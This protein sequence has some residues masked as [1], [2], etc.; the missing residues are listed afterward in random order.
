MIKPLALNQ[1]STQIPY[2]DLKRQFRSLEKEIRQEINGVLESGQFVLGSKVQT[3]EKS[4]AKYLGVKH[5]IGVASG[6]DALILAF[7]ALGIGK[8]DQVIVP[9]YTYTAS[10]F[11]FMH[12]GAEPVFV[13]I[14]PK[15]FCINPDLIEKAITP[16]TK[17]I[18]PVHL[19]GQAANMTAIMKIARK[20]KLKV[21]ED[22]AQ[23][24]GA[25]W[26]GKKAGTFGDFGCFSFYPTKNLGAYGDGGM[27]VTNSATLAKK[28]L[29]LRNLGHIS[30][31]AD[32]SELG[33]TSRL[34]ELQACVLEIKLKH[35]DDF[36]RK[37]Y[38]L[39]QHYRKNLKNTPVIFP[40]EVS[41][42]GS[43]Y[44]L[45]VARIPQGKRETLRDYLSRQGVTTLVHYKTPVHLQPFYR[46][47]SKKSWDLPA[48]LQT[49]R[50][51]V[52]LPLFPEMTFEE[53][54]QVCDHIQKFYKP[55]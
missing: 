20:H 28:I 48:T 32:H 54:N 8:G 38:E 14:D 13:D 26:K 11:G 4:F 51:I 18:L 42:A 41:D 31:H 12:H 16:K 29:T 9:S 1:S 45:M 6:T 17:A 15:T 37:R 46:K 39:A 55:H 43:A 33:W 10:V 36:N 19:Y 49:T 50:E 47:Q 5:A 7:R 25:S 53:V 30:F 44:H 52:S 3:F 35:L 2:F 40:E 34:D 23:A 24:H 22:V 21:V 27:V